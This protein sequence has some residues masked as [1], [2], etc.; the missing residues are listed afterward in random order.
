MLKFIILG[1]AFPFFSH[2]Q[3]PYWITKNP[4]ENA[5]SLFYVGNAIANSESE[6]LLKAIEEV[7]ILLVM[8]N[9]GFVAQIKVNSHETM[10]DQDLSKKFKEISSQIVI[11]GLKLEE[12]YTDE[13]SKYW[14]LFSYDKK[15]LAIEKR[16]LVDEPPPKLTDDEPQIVRHVIEYESRAEKDRKESQ[17]K[18][19]IK[20]PDGV[21]GPP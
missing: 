16:R 9:Y 12:R 20:H 4:K 19:K 13:E 10:E 2:A 5:T 3:E 18:F 7:K 14:F 1:M 6:A 17:I 15:Q 21:F 11:K 8:E